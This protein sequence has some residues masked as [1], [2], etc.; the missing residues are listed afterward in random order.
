MYTLTI[1]NPPEDVLNLWGC[2]TNREVRFVR[3]EDEKDALY[4]FL[5]VFAE[6]CHIKTEPGKPFYI[7]YTIEKQVETG[8]FFSD[9]I[10]TRF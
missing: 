9:S 7:R 3:S 10:P 1:F 5:K 2:K 8:S 6:T 4:S